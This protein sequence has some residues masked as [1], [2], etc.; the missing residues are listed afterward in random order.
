MHFVNSKLHEGQ[1]I[2]W[3]LLEIFIHYDESRNLLTKNILY[4]VHHVKLSTSVTSK[5]LKLD[6]KVKA[7]NHCDGGKSCQTVAEDIGVGRTQIM[8]ILQ[9]KHEIFDDF[10]NNVSSSTSCYW[11]L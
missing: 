1:F 9:R 10:E 8:N 3:G 4:L 11:K 7:I 5:A 2:P 6:D